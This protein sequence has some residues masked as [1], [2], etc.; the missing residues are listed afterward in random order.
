MRSLFKMTLVTLTIFCNQLPGNG[1]QARDLT[2]V[3]TPDK[4][5]FVSQDGDSGMEVSIVREALATAG[6]TVKTHPITDYR[7][8]DVLK[9]QFIDGVAGVSR[10]RQ[11]PSGT[12]ENNSIFFSDEYI[13]YQDYAITL[14]SAH[15]A[16]ESVSDLKGHTVVAFNNARVHLGPDYAD[17]VD[18]MGHAPDG[19]EMY[20]ETNRKSTNLM[21]W[22]HRAE[23]LIADRTIFSWYRKELASVVDTSPS[24]T[25]HRIFPNHVFR[26]VVFK[27]PLVRDDFNRGLRQLCDRGRYYQIYDDATRM[28]EFA[29][30]DVP[31]PFASD[32][33]KKL[34]SAGISPHGG[35]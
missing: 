34:G 23:I 4:A 18:S 20:I 30:G 29:F 35:E 31:V 21:F 9:L 24:V 25:F 15:I 11:Y 7:L 8:E 22:R 12:L 10:L 13:E 28:A 16:L 14:T 19:T 6:Y 27:D 3:F 5:P 2:I 32:V 17:I 33:C 1:G 26:T